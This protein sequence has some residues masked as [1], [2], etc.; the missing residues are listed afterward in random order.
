MGMSVVTNVA[1]LASHR[2]LTRSNDAASRSLER[3]SSGFRI[4][5]AADDAA[6]LAISRNL[7]AQ[8]TGLAQ[9]IRNTQDGIGV[10]RTADGGLEAATSILQPMRDLSVQAANDG[11]LSDGATE[12][13][14]AE[15]EQLKSEL[16][17]IAATTS[18]NG[19][20]LLDGTYRGTFQI[21]ANAGETLTVEIGS[22]FRTSSAGLG[23]TTVDATGGATD[24]TLVATVTPASS[25]AE[26]IRAPGRVLLAGDFTTPG[27]Y[28]ASFAGLVGSVTY[29]G[30]SFDLAGVDFTG[31][32]TATHYITRLQAAAVPFFGNPHTPFT[33]S[34]PGLTFTGETPGAGSTAPDAV[35][36]TPGYRGRSGAGAAISMIDDAVS[37]ISSLRAYLG[38]VENRFEH[39]IANL[40]TTMENT[41]AALSRIED[42]DMAWEMTTFSRSQILSQA[43]TAMLAQANGAPRNVLTLL[44]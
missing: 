3:L 17:R 32:V 27:A 25:E 36:L 13:V 29:E 12:A 7:R 44:N 16:D 9:A 1:A 42:T 33:G 28:P 23:L 18:F 10:L 26:G 40:G 20:P 5:R 15:V 35:A 39:T 34:A 31:A 8:T 19:R 38:A 6:G 37:T 11:G 2:S 43:G 24:A 4:N 41:A 30:K 21:G 22:G 14:Q